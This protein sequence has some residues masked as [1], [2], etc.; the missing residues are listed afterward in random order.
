MSTGERLRD[1]LAGDGLVVVPGV[2]DGLSA[3]VADAVGFDAV[4]MTGNG[5]V[6]SRLGR[7]DV[8]TATVVEMAEHARRLQEA[9]EVPLIADADNGYGNAVN[10]IRTVREFAAA[11]VAAIHVEDQT[12][13]KRCGF[14]EGKQVVPVE[15]AVGKFRAA[16]DVRDEVRPDLVLIA[17]TDARGAPGGTIAD[18]IERVHAY[19]E[20]GAD[21]G[22]VQ[23]PADADE[24]AAVGEAVDAPL[25]YN[26]SGGS[27]VVPLAEAEAMGYDLAMF[28]RLSTLP[29]IT[30]LFE[31]YGRLREA[32]MDAWTEAAAAFEAAPVESYDH[33]TGVPE[34]L[35]WEARYLPDA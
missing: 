4:S 13:P 22:F 21:V 1:L 30:A 26:V 24:L 7:P 33:L 28:P 6:L 16:A 10:L 9:V 2:H 23:G 19:L 27:P 11:G 3:R 18:A 32:G 29:A 25:L 5:A 34:V 17:R 12:F 8:G 15:E 35:D 31:S 20:A 14:V